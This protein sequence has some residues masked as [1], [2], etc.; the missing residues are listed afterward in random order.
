M[1]RWNGGFDW[2]IMLGLMGGESFRSLFHPICW[3]FIRALTNINFVKVKNEHQTKHIFI[4]VCTRVCGTKNTHHVVSIS[5]FNSLTQMHSTPNFFFAAIEHFCYT[6]SLRCSD[7][8]LHWISSFSSS[9]ALVSHYTLH[10]HVYTYLS[11]YTCYSCAFFGR[12]TN[13]HHRF[14][15]YLFQKLRAANET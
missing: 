7:G 15:F 1:V 13:N 12:C 10:S 2:N 11:K 3:S 14:W 8:P 5:R 9:F 6:A 4:T